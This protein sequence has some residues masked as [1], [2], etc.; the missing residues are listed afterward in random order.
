MRVDA[1]DIEG[2]TGRSGRQRETRQREWEKGKASLG[3]SKGSEVG[4]TKKIITQDKEIRYNSLLIAM[5]THLS[6]DERAQE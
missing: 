1:Q 6:M 4:D 2:V 5:A 3:L